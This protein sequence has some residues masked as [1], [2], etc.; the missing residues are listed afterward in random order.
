MALHVMKPDGYKKEVIHNAVGLSKE[1]IWIFWSIDMATPVVI[2]SSRQDITIETEGVL[3]QLASVDND[4]PWL[5]MGDFNCVLRNEEKKGGREPRT[6]VINDFS[7][8]ME[9]NDL[10]E[11]DFLDSKYTWANVSDHSTLIGFPFANPRIKRAPFRVQK[12]WFSHQDFMRMV[13]ESWNAPV[14]G[15]PFF[16]YPFNLKRLK[17]TMKEWNLQVF[18]NV[19]AKLKQA[20]LTMEVALR[21]SDEDPEDIAKIN[22]AKEASVTLQEI[23]SQQSIMLKQKFRNKWLT[24]GSSNTSFFHANIRTRRSSDLISELVDDNGNTLNDFDQI[25]NYAVSFFES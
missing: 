6:L 1:N 8:W 17:A 25:R 10:F 14:S 11:A 21:I 3:Q 5:V 19:Y 15:S 12:M 22:S 16:I 9:D 4:T 13:I 18:G 2:N 23:R 20:K 7:D 24:D